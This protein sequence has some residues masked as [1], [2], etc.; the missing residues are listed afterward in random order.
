[1]DLEY[2]HPGYHLGDLPQLRGAGTGTA[3]KLECTWDQEHEA[4][5]DEHRERER[6]KRRATPP[7][8]HMASFPVPCPAW[9]PAFSHLELRAQPGQPNPGVTLFSIAL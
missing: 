5:L 2:L 6:A 3:L 4:L 9:H 1:M 7:C 8:L